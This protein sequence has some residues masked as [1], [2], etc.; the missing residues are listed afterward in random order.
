VSSACSSDRIRPG[1]PAVI[2]SLAQTDAS[3]TDT[4]H[5][6]VL[7]TAPEGVDSVFVVLGTE[8]LGV[9]GRFDVEVRFA[10]RWGLESQFAPGDTA[11]FVAIARDLDRLVARD[12]ALVVIR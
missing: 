2:I 3:P 4:I 12:T 10:F 7:A 5:G 8:E 9:D 6:S 11:V 1:P